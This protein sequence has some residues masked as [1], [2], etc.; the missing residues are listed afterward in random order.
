MK[1]TDAKTMM[2]TSKTTKTDRPAA[3][4]AADAGV[5]GEF[6]RLR[7]ILARTHTEIPQLLARQRT[8]ERALGL[9]ETEALRKELQGVAA[10]RESAARRRAAAIQAVLD[11]D[12]PLQAERAGLER[13]RQQY[14]T[15]ALAQFRER[16]SACV[17]D[18]QALWE[19]GRALGLA[20]RC[21]VPM[22]LPTKVVTSLDGV[23]RGVPVRA[24]VVGVVDDEAAQLGAKLDLLDGALAMVNAIRQSQTFDQHHHRLGL[25]RGAGA[26]HSGVYRVL[27][28]FQCL[29][30]GLEFLPGQLVDSSLIGAGMAHRLQVGRR[31]IEPAGLQTSAAA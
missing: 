11:L 19:A 1:T 26:E 8:M 9:N 6:D 3:M 20:L 18:L 12:A 16:Y 10:E 29:T 27:Q 13:S 2:T 23:A 14:A 17:A 30:D 22:P 24:D 25:L 15:H 5:M 7:E 21:E 28:P 31:H 4:P